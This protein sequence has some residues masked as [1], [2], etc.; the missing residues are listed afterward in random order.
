VLIV[1]M[2]VLTQG[3]QQVSLIEDQGTVEEFVAAGLDPAFH[4]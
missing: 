2:F 3:V 1:V 4:D